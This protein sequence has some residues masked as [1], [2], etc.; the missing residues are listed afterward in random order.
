MPLLEI[1]AITV[2][3]V[4]IIGLLVIFIRKAPLVAAI[5]VGLQREPQQEKKQRLIERRLTRKFLSW[6]APTAEVVRPA[7]RRLATWWGWLHRHL[8]D[9]E[10]EYRVRSLPVFLDRRQKH[11]VQNEIA[12]ILKQ[13]SACVDE[14]EY[15]AAEEKCLQAIRLNPRCI[16]AFEQLGALYRRRHEYQHAKEVYEFLL[17]LVGEDDDEG[18][19]VD[20]P[21]GSSS[22]PSSV[23][24]ADYHLYAA[25]ALIHLANQKMAWPH[26]ETALHHEPNNPRVL[27]AYIEI[28]LQCGKKGF[29]AAAIAKVKETNPD[30]AKIADW[31]QRAAA[32]DEVAIRHA[33][34]DPVDAS[35][36]LSEDVKD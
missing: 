13:A 6:W 10:H 19:L 29:A 26:A 35:Q 20:R 9:L 22:A 14:G 27:D 2:V 4:A 34:V 23:V 32:L 15:S 3:A 12:A 1:I 17:K 18:E 8:K 16:P 11:K 7:G 36:E 5:D 28:S 24:L 33:A 31:E 25:D 30:N 21:G